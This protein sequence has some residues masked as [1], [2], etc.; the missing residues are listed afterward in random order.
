MSAPARPDRRTFLGT[1]AAGLLA[2]PMLAR[3]AR[4]QQSVTVASLLA[5][6]KPETL[7]W[8]RIA[9]RMEERMPG[10]FAFNI[11]PN[12]ALGGEREVAQNARLGAVQGSLSTV[13]VMSAWVPETQILDLPFLFRDAAHLKAVTGGEI[14]EAL[15]ARLRDAGFVAPSFIDYGARQLLS[16]SPIRRPSE[17]RGLNMRVIQSPLHTT[18]WSGYGAIPTGIPIVE[19]YNALETGVVDAMDLTKSAYA[20]FNLYEVVPDLT[21]TSHIRAAGIVYFSRAFWDGLDAEHREVLGEEVRAAAG[22]FDA[23]I[24]RDEVRAMEEARAGGGVVVEPEEME[25]WIAGARPVWE[26]MAE[27]VG[28]MDRIEAIRETG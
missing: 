9:D 23:L 3:P 21:E 7:I 24:V 12:A 26:E 18:L 19:V 2:A 8:T 20:G 25:A 14:G 15:R 13:S 27:S 5:A 22:Y 16:K 11:V 28:G 17:L 4:A 1:G 10:A 6:D